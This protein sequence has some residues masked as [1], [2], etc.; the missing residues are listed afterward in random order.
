MTTTK[1]DSKQPQLSKKWL[2]GS[3]AVIALI[4]GVVMDKEA[5]AAESDSAVDTV[6]QVKIDN[7]NDEVEIDTSMQNDD[8]E[9]DDFEGDMED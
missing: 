4:I 8:F 3:L 6:E 5:V 2:Y 7:E 1:N 9:A